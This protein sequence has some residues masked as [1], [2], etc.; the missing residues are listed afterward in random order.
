MPILNEAKLFLGSTRLDGGKGK[1]DRPAD[2]LPLDLPE[3]GVNILAA[4][5]SSGSHRMGMWVSPGTTIDWGDG[6]SPETVSVTRAQTAT[7]GFR[8][9]QV[10]SGTA[11]YGDFVWGVIAAMWDQ[12]GDPVAFTQ[13]IPNNTFTLTAPFDG[14]VYIEVQG[15]CEFFIE[16]EATSLTIPLSDLD[17]KKAITTPTFYKLFEADLSTEVGGVTYDPVNNT[18]T[19]T[20]LLPAG[21][22]YITSIGL[23]KNQVIGGYPTYFGVDIEPFRNDLSTGISKEPVEYGTVYFC[24]QPKN[25]RRADDGTPVT[26]GVVASSTMDTDVAVVF[27]RLNPSFDSETEILYDLDVRNLAYVSHVYDCDDSVFNGTENF[28][29]R[30]QAVIQLTSS[31]VTSG[32]CIGRR[33]GLQGLMISPIEIKV[34]SQGFTNIWVDNA[35]MLQ[36]VEIHD[37]LISC[38]G[39]D[40]SRFRECSV[41]RLYV[42]LTNVKFAER[43]VDYAWML[44]DVEFKNAG[45]VLVWNSTFRESSLTEYPRGLDFTSAKY[46]NLFMDDNQAMID[47][48]A[49]FN[50]PNLEYLYAFFDDSNALLYGPTFIAPELKECGKYVDAENLLTPIDPN[51]FVNLSELTDFTGNPPTYFAYGYNGFPSGATFENYIQIGMFYSDPLAIDLT[52]FGNVFDHEIVNRG[53]YDFNA[54]LDWP[55]MTQ[56]KLDAMIETLEDISDAPVGGNIAVYVGGDGN[57]F[58]TSAAADKGWD[59]EIYGY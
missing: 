5:P 34:N 48:R 2:F 19:T 28:L 53:E 39:S 37:N 46:I 8:S 16:A 30:K 42:D 43:I 59:L 32:L 45:N 1:Y 24:P 47:G 38:F 58:D 9:Q 25:F 29:G 6:S 26:S 18:I 13:D 57:G 31:E 49:T 51:T 7:A 15:W 23:I 35:K 14:Y 22:Y 44:S 54:N 52:G 36:S 27:D 17:I 55:S 40:H 41:R 20:T 12:N 50:C 4:L 10:D 33:N 3:D 11:T 21:W 56:A